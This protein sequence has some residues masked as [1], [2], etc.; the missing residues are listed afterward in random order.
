MTVKQLLATYRDFTLH[1]HE[2]KKRINQVNK[3][4]LKK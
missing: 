1:L 2:A 3:L 4:Q